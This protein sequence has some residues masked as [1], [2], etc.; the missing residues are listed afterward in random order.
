MFGS[1]VVRVAK[2]SCTNISRSVVH[3]RGT[4]SDMSFRRGFQ[5]F[6]T[7]ADI[8]GERN[9]P[10]TCGRSARLTQTKFAISV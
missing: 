6:F 2:V 9:A 10:P 8:C 4:L 5:V 3:C 1:V 7:L